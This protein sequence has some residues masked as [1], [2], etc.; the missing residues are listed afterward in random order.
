M[1]N[2][3]RHARCTHDYPRMAQPLRPLSYVGAGLAGGAVFLL[4]ELTLLP[5]TKHLPAIW[6]LRLVAALQA[7]PVALYEPTTQWPHVPAVVVVVLPALGMHMALSLAFAFVFCKAEDELSLSGSIVVSALL[8]VALYLQNFYI[9]TL[10]FPWFETARG[11]AT[12]LAHVLYG[13][14]TALTHKGLR[15]VRV[16]RRAAA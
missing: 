16:P 13:V 10:L 1:R 12:I 7:G 15:R 11:G 6:F 3:Q 4:V 5:L 9:F 2:A 14:T 8:G